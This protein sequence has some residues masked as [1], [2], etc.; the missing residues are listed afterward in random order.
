MEVF[1]TLADFDS[2]WGKRKQGKKKKKKKAVG[3]GGGRV[4]KRFRSHI[5]LKSRIWST[6]MFATMCVT[7]R[8]RVLIVYVGTCYIKVPESRRQL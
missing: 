2:R 4:F 8:S 7:L 1:I 6:L 3:G 5:V